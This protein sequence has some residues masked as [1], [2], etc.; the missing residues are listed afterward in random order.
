MGLYD[1]NG[2]RITR[3]G[4]PSTPDPNPDPVVVLTT[5]VYESA[6]Y[7]LYDTAPEGTMRR[8]LFK[9]GTKVRESQIAALFPAAVIAAVTPATGPAVGGTKVTISGDNLD[10]VSGV[11]FAGAAGTGLAVVS[12]SE[13]TVT[14]PAGVAG[15]V[16]VTAADDA[17]GVTLPGGFTYT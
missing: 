2:N 11:T 10:G 13:V 9:A 14:T 3:A 1:A 5:D 16:N 12:A 17:G 6:T 15:P 4:F 7:G 8:F